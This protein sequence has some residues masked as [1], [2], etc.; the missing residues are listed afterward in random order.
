[1]SS[2]S[3]DGWWSVPD[4]RSDTLWKHHHLRLTVNSLTHITHTRQTSFPHGCCCD[5]HKHLHKLRAFPLTSSSYIIVSSRC[6]QTDPFSVGLVLRARARSKGCVCIAYG[7]KA[8]ICIT[9]L[10]HQPIP[11]RTCPPRHFCVTALQRSHASL[12]SLTDTLRK[13]CHL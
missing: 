13:G 3:T 5:K 12:H 8:S 2:Q 4:H 6:R 11:L 10:R 9:A 1:M 7:A